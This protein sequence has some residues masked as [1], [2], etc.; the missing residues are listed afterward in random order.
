MLGTW[1]EVWVDDTGSKP[2][3]LIITNDSSDLSRII[4]IDPIEGYKVVH[5]DK[6][7]SDI[8]LWLLE[9]EYKIVD[10]RMENGG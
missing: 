6:E 1:F 2:Y 4:V 3:L 5:L 10:G 8:K 9:D 7:Y